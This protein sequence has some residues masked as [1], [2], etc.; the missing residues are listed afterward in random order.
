[1][2][3]RPARLR[4]YTR[5]MSVFPRAHVLA[6]ALGALALAACDGGQEAAEPQKPLFKPDRSP[7]N[8]LTASID[9]KAMLTPSMKRSLDSAPGKITFTA[10]YDGEPVGTSTSGPSIARSAATAAHGTRCAQRM[11][12]HTLQRCRARPASWVL[13]ACRAMGIPL[14]PQVCV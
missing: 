1:M 8:M 4:V 7:E 14:P 10:P 13:P 5:P 11:P 6:L 2:L 12:A 9:P 3:A